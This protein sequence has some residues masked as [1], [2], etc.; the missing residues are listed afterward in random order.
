[1]PILA[2]TTNAA[3]IREYLD[4][5]G[6]YGLNG[7][8]KQGSPPDA[9]G[10]MS[11]TDILEWLS[12]KQGATSPY[13]PFAFREENNLVDPE[14]GAVI[15]SETGT[16]KIAPE[17]HGRAVF[18]EATLTLY[19]LVDGALSK[20]VYVQRIPG[21]IDLHRYESGEDIFG[22]DDVFVHAFSG[23]TYQ[24]S[25]R[26]W[27]KNSARSLVLAQVIADCIPFGQG[28]AHTHGELNENGMV[29]LNYWKR[30]HRQPIDF[31]NPA[32]PFIDANP[33]IHNPHANEWGLLNLISHSVND[34]LHFRSA[35]NRREWV[36][37]APGYNA[38]IP[39]TPKEDLYAELVYLVHDLT[40]YA[41]PD[42]ALD[43]NDTP[44]NRTVYILHRM[45]GEAF[46]MVMADMI[47]MDSM[48]RSE[49]QDLNH[50]GHGIY[51]LFQS[52]QFNPALSQRERLTQLLW[53][54]VS[55]LLLGD[56]APYLSLLRKAEDGQPTQGALAIFE[57]FKVKYGKFALADF[58]WTNQNYANAMNQPAQF[59]D[60]IQCV[61]TDE[62]AR[63]KLSVLTPYTRSIETRVRQQGGRPTSFASVARGVFDEIMERTFA[64]KLEHAAQEVS[65]E[66]ANS[67]AFRRYMIGQAALFAK[68]T[69]PWVAE[70]A[71]R[72]MDQ[73]R[74]IEM[75]SQGDMQS[76]RD[77]FNAVVDQ[78]HTEHH[79]T[80]DD[81][82][83]FKH[84]FPMVRPVY[85]SYH[86]PRYLTIPEMHEDIFGTPA[87][88]GLPLPS[89]V[90]P[91]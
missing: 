33:V 81:S 11:D 41:S 7:A 46:A 50:Q 74:S 80:Q 26:A 67:R 79:I 14:T 86:R 61:G 75:F 90:T 63:A 70:A 85:V 38:G 34:G 44:L 23:K 2:L 65:T 58:D 13:P 49:V 59:A 32:K 72:I 69:L 52:L 39:L 43:G 53:A 87:E 28:R 16:R 56:D 15:P 62:F 21:H 89:T 6:E 29:D 8:I 17:N 10:G 84:V 5:F 73:V 51:P 22:W 37:W 20:K 48:V 35:S 91:Y 36:Y 64:P 40:H 76:I 47:F 88:E 25:K 42:L 57:A 54:A 77:Q 71:S 30:H 45:M 3:K 82:R 78:L 12:E 19:R 4:Q 31:T 68:Y 83:V 66:V 27:G 60:W 9:P 1:M 55:S 18:N 24:E